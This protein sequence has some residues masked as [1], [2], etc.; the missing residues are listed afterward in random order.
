VVSGQQHTCKRKEDRKK[1]K[2]Q[3]KKER[4]KEMKK[5]RERKRE[6]KVTTCKGK[7]KGKVI[8]LQARCGPA[9]LEGGE[10]S[11]AHV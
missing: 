8:P 10:W 6:R 4:E 2:K 1:G 5:E 7:G 9:V 11:A 3:R